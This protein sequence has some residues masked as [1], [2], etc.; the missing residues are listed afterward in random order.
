MSALWIKNRIS[1]QVGDVLHDVG[2][3][4]AGDNDAL[5]GGKIAHDLEC[6]DAV[7]ARDLLEQAVGAGGEARRQR[8]AFLGVGY[9]QVAMHGS[10]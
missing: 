8:L 1:P 2:E 5:L 7:L 4:L 10:R 9:R 6:A 3:R